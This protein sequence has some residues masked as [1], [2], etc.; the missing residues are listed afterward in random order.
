MS[1][2]NSA[3]VNKNKSLRKKISSV[4]TRVCAP[5]LW[6]REPPQMTLFHFTYHTPSTA[7]V[8]ARWTICRRL[9]FGSLPTSSKERVKHTRIERLILHSNCAPSMR[10]ISHLDISKGCWHATDKDAILA[11]YLMRTL[12]LTLSAFYRASNKLIH[13][14]IDPSINTSIT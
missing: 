2:K 9:R 3:N 11:L 5:H 10:S 8:C 4:S 12:S 7:P 13:R 6:V 14:T 1:G